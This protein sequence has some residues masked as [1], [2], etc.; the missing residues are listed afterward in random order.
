MGGCWLQ[1][2]GSN[3]NEWTIVRQSLNKP[4][5]VWQAAVRAPLPLTPLVVGND[6]MSYIL[7]RLQNEFASLTHFMME[8]LRKEHEIERGIR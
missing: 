7:R 2:G 6:A 4:R 1:Q 3:W 8:T 5:M